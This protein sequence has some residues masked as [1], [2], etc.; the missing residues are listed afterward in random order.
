MS[1]SWEEEPN[2]DLSY[3]FGLNVGVCDFEKNLWFSFL[4]FFLFSNRVRG[5][6]ADWEDGGY[7]R[8]RGSCFV[9]RGYLSP[10]HQISVE[11]ER[12]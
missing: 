7:R 1:L 6:A 5:A 9:L 3:D 8:W 12:W 10:L 4:D 11:E 2:H